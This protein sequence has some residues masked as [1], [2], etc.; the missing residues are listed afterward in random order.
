MVGDACRR[1]VGQRLLEEGH[2]LV[3][4]PGQRVRVAE[5]PRG[6][7]EEERRRR[8]PAQLDGALERRNGLRDIAAAQGH[9]PTLRKPLTGLAG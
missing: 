6:D 4:A 7:V 1:G 9:D 2:A 3:E 5:V 8:H